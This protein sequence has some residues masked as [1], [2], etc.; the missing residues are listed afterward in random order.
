[1][2]RKHEP[3]RDAQAGAESDRAGTGHAGIDRRGSR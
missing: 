1:M 3:E 2:A